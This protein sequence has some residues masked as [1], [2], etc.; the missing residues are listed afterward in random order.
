LCRQQAEALQK[1]EDE[2]VRRI[3][4]GEARHGKYKKLKLGGGHSY[5]ASSDSAAVVA[6]DK[7]S[8]KG[9]IFNNTLCVRY[10]QFT[11]AKD[12]HKG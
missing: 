4:E 3:G 12:I 5:D 11:K 10:V 8:A 7:Y 2:H 9:R 1:H 6:Y